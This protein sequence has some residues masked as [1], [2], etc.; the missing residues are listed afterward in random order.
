VL[1]EAIVDVGHKALDE[2]L[3]QMR[4]EGEMQGNKGGGGGGSD[5]NGRMMT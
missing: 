3:K 2:H 4:G 5:E 1:E